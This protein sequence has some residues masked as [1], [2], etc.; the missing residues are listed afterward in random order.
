MNVSSSNKNFPSLFVLS[1]LLGIKAKVLSSNLVFVFQ[2][3]FQL[4]ILHVGPLLLNESLSPHIRG[5][6]EYK[7]NDY[8][9]PFI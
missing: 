4:N 1:F 5:V 6:L 2:L 8:I 7:L 9:H 3:L